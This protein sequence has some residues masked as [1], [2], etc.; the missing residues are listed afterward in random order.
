MEAPSWPSFAAT[1][2][3]SAVTVLS[4]D[5]DGGRTG[6]SAVAFRAGKSGD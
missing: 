4:A 6:V 2:P 5:G 3:V 1:V